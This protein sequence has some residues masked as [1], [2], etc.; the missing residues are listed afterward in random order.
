M[1]RQV[2]FFLIGF[3]CFALAAN[4]QDSLAVAQW[5]ATEQSLVVLR[6]E[7]PLLPLTSVDVHLV[8]TF[9]LGDTSIFEKTCAKY[10]DPQL[11]RKPSPQEVFLFAMDGDEYSPVNP[12]YS[13]FEHEMCYY[14]ERRMEDSWNVVLV[15]F[16][17]PAI[18]DMLPDSKTLKAIVSVPGL[19]DVS[20]SLAAQLIFGGIGA[21]GRLSRN[22]NDH[23]KK[24]DGLI[25][26]GNI[27]LGYCPPELVGMNSRLL[28]D[29]ISA[30]VNEGIRAKAF[31]GAQVLVAK[32]GKV[33]FHEAY[34]FHTYD[35]LQKVSTTDLY[36]FASLTKVTA[37]L[38]A[39][40]KLYGEGKFDLDAPLKGYLP[41]FKKSN[42]A[43]I[44]CRQ[45]LAHNGRLK[46]SIVFWREAKNADGTWKRR[47][48]KD[49]KTQHYSIRI[50]DQLYLHKKYKKQIFKEIRVQPLNEKPGY[51]YSDLSFILYPEVVKKLTKQRNLETYLHD[52]F[53]GPLGASSLVYN[54]L[55]IFPPSQIVPTERDTFFRHQQVHGTVHDETAAMLGGVS[56][57]AGLFGNANDLAKLFQMY[58]N[59]GEYG[60]KRLIAK[61]AVEEFTR[62]Q[63]CAEGNRRGLGFDKPLI[64]YNANAS[65]VARSAS[66][67]SFGHSG[68]TGT[69]VWADPKNNLLVIFFS[70][71]VYPFRSS[72]GIS[73]LNIRPRIHQV[74]YDAI[75]PSPK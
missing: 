1:N 3:S 69:F 70:N 31:P 11:L 50:T 22:I 38:P 56:G 19:D 21:S 37:T 42:K 12:E 52:T 63:F 66:P 13:H 57:H 15:V 39:L 5:R 67:Q 4:S 59:G 73:T 35:S 74:A 36:D 17:N 24:G 26:M 55:K 46:P 48:F 34:G 10:F 53:Y 62:C 41:F 49:H 65:Y 43:D 60:G 14:L 58:L 54:P 64:E 29:S 75:Q 32:N 20:Q 47:S 18:L 44:T 68:Y 27:R 61:S 33:I 30:I 9:G 25:T 23:F 16:G 2:I 28:Y 72:N 40:M 45:L 6:N 7:G 51:V 71:R 8:R